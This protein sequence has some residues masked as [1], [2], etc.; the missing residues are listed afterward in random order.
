MQPPSRQVPCYP[1]KSSSQLL[2]QLALVWRASHVAVS[3]CALHC[4]SVYVS[5]SV[6]IF[7]AILMPAWCEGFEL[8]KMR[9]P[10]DDNPEPLSRR[11][12]C[13]LLPLSA[14]CVALTCAGIIQ[15]LQLLLHIAR[16][17]AA[18]LIHHV[19]AGRKIRPLSLQI[20]RKRMRM[21]GS[22]L[23]IQI[24]KNWKC[25]IQMIC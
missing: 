2:H 12:R 1:V 10:A 4:V 17:S 22:C 16:V 14:A 13:D 3:S 25:L 21:K 5:M 18:M 24:G 15:V 8:L 20:R 7:S 11:V 23:H 9:L 6:A 19:I